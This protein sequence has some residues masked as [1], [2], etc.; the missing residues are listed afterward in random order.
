MFRYYQVCSWQL[1]TH[2]VN[3]PAP[4]A[5]GVERHLPRADRRA[6]QMPVQA[7][8]LRPWGC[9]AWG[10]GLTQVQDVSMEKMVT[11]WHEISSCSFNAEM[12]KEPGKQ[13]RH[14]FF[15]SVWVSGLTERCTVAW[16]VPSVNHVLSNGIVSSET[17]LSYQPL[18]PFWPQTCSS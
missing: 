12:Q 6:Q 16:G 3:L 4:E 10:R 2:C 5:P 1:H 14:S 8:C 17:N 9:A 15:C 18:V 13:L 11:S 7:Q